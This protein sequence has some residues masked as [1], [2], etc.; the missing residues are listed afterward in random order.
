MLEIRRLT[1]YHI[2]KGYIWRKRNKWDLRCSVWTC[3]LLLF[4][5]TSTTQ[6]SVASVIYWYLRIGLE[7]TKV[8]CRW[9]TDIQIY[10][11]VFNAYTVRKGYRFSRPQPG[12]HQINDY[13]FTVYSLVYLSWPASLNWPLTVLEDAVV[14]LQGQVVILQL[15]QRFVCS[16]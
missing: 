10:W 13:L 16:L 12:Y 11:F 5:Y 9:K 4:M 3:P 8:K 6:C 14:L 2:E 7:G 1:N 15:G